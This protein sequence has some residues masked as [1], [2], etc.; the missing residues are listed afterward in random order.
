MRPTPY[1][2]ATGDFAAHDWRAKSLR[3]H[4]SLNLF[5][6]PTASLICDLLRVTAVFRDRQSGSAV[7]VEVR[8]VSGAKKGTWEAPL[9][10]AWWLG[11]VVSNISLPIVVPVTP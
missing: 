8:A 1:P 2:H 5:Y 4:H 6:L 3:E 11:K 10:L 7:L 9:E